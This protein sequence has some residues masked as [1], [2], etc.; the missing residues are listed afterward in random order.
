MWNILHH[1][2]AGWHL[3]VWMH[4]ILIEYPTVT[5]WCSELSAEIVHTPI[6]PLYTC[7]DIK[8]FQWTYRWFYIFVRHTE[9]ILSASQEC[10]LQ[11]WAAQMVV[12][13]AGEGTSNKAGWCQLGSRCLKHQF[14]TAGYKVTLEGFITDSLCQSFFRRTRSC[15]MLIFHSAF[16][17]LSVRCLW[18]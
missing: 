1:V 8:S 6:L 7:V 12:L 10:A 13:T 9:T 17:R 15:L 5:I 2:V 4:A 16:T 3:C 11:R 14:L 18:I